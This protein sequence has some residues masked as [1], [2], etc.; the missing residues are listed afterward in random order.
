MCDRLFAI[1]IA[2][3]NTV[4]V[5]AD[6]GKNVQNFFIARVDTVKDQGHDDLLPRWATLIPELGLLQVDDVPDILH[7][8]VQGT[9]CQCL[10]FVVVGD[11]D[12]EFGMPI[13]HRRTQVVTVVQSKLV[14]IT[15][16]GSV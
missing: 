13:I 14:G 7:D 11:S 12:Q 8:A 6:S 2:L 16:R 5:D 4:L 15:R 9:G 3:H 1:D 10:V